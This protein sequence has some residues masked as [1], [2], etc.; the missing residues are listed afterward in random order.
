M[1]RIMAQPSLKLDNK[2]YKA[3]LVFIITEE[4]LLVVPICLYV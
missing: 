2:K 1:K 3:T 4:G